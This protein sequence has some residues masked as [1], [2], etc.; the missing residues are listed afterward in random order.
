MR[1]CTVMPMGLAV[2]PS[3]QSI[4]ETEVTNSTPRSSARVGGGMVPELNVSFALLVSSTTFLLSPARTC[5]PRA[6]PGSLLSTLWRVSPSYKVI[7]PKF[8]ARV[9]S[10]W[11]TGSLDITVRFPSFNGTVSST[12]RKSL[13]W[14]R[15]T[16]RKG[17]FRYDGDMGASTSVGELLRTIFWFNQTQIW[18]LAQ[19]LSVWCRV[20][21]EATH[22]A[23]SRCI[24]EERWR[25]IVEFA[26]DKLLNSEFNPVVTIKVANCPAN[27]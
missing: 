17:V 22:A 25:A 18:R 4:T 21:N 20:S 26:A 23:G 27:K 11:S 14:S 6:G 12:R 2:S 9:C 10:N 7:S 5:V 13:S 3:S 24:W 16:P 15:T 1:V 8:A 19:C